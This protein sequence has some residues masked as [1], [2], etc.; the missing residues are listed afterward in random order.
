[1]IG[2]HFQDISEYKVFDLHPNG[3]LIDENDHIVTNPPLRFDGS[4]LDDCPPGGFHGCDDYLMPYIQVGDKLYNYLEFYGG[5]GGYYIGDFIN[6]SD[7]ENNFY[8]AISISEEDKENFKDLQE[9]FGN[10]NIVTVDVT[11][12]I[13]NEWKSD[14]RPDSSDDSSD[15]D[16]EIDINEFIR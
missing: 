8:Q 4:T 1:M 5:D 10:L 12:L 6:C 7:M 3:Q 13:E 2:V 11:D 9:H 15:Q 16:Q 14:L